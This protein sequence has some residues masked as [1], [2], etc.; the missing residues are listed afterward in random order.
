MQLLVVC[1]CVCVCALCGHLIGEYYVLSSRIM[2]E[3]LNRCVLR[4]VP[5]GAIIREAK[6]GKGRKGMGT[7]ASGMIYIGCTMDKVCVGER[8]KCACRTCKTNPEPIKIVFTLVHYQFRR[9]YRYC[10]GTLV[11]FDFSNFVSW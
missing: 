11:S 4:L 9:Y 2:Y 3:N 8:T 10:L 7:K 6:W 5:I 1:A